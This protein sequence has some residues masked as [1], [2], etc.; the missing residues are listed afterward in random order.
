MFIEGEDPRLKDKLGCS[1]AAL[2]QNPKTG[3]IIA[4]LGKSALSVPHSVILS[5]LCCHS[6][7][8][9]FLFNILRSN[10]QN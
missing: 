6:V 10:G 8:I 7:L 3:F 9:L 1:T 4:Q 2:R 5:L